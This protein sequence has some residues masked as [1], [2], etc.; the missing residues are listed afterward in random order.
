MV[1]N[2]CEGIYSREE[3]WDHI[4]SREHQQALHREN[5][6]APTAVLHGYDSPVKWEPLDRVWDDESPWRESDDDFATDDNN[7]LV[8][9]SWR[10]KEAAI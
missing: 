1:C 4:I 9:W 8:P 6:K 5:V 7:N 2:V 3:W 10:A